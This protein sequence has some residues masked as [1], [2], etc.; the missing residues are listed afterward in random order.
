MEESVFYKNMLP[1][2]DSENIEKQ[3]TFTAVF[4]LENVQILI[5][6]FYIEVT[7]ERHVET[8]SNERAPHPV[9]NN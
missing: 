9:S 2:H 4:I 7:Q 6:H 3:M 5:C 1:A 8:E